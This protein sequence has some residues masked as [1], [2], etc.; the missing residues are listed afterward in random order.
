MYI[1]QNLHDDIK[2]IFCFR[3]FYLSFLICCNIYCIVILSL[4]YKTWWLATISILN[5]ILITISLLH[6]RHLTQNKADY[7]CLCPDLFIIIFMGLVIFV[8]YFIIALFKSDY[9]VYEFIIM[10]IYG[11]L[12][13]GIILAVVIC[14]V[15]L[16][17][18]SINDEARTTL[19]IDN[20]YI[21]E[22]R[23]KEN[24][25]DTDEIISI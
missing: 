4:G 9:I 16:I 6:L 8:P 18:N 23:K 1:Y 11:I 5:F 14:S 21:I 15:L 20:E 2:N 19:L 7:V 24:I 13:F 12:C 25:L 17:C 22:K 3:I 10:L